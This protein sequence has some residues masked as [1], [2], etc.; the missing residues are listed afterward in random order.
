MN[1]SSITIS[2]KENSNGGYDIQVYGERKYALYFVEALL[3]VEK[4]LGVHFITEKDA[5]GESAEN[6]ST[7]A[8]L[9]NLIRI[10]RTSYKTKGKL[11]TKRE[12]DLK[13]PFTDLIIIKKF[14]EIAGIKFDEQKFQ[15]RREF[16]EYFKTLLKE[17]KRK[18]GWRWK[19]QKFGPNCKN[20]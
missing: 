8:L 1:Q 4:P 9:S 16:Q 10:I 20:G 13:F 18:A 3:S 6:S 11:I 2:W 15:N 5:N 14:A 19:N 7:V 17:D 12:Q